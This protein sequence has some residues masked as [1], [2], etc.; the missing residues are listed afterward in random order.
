M[1]ND[2]RGLSDSHRTLRSVVS[3]PPAAARPGIALGRPPVSSVEDDFGLF[4]L[5]LGKPRRRTADRL[6]AFVSGH[7][8]SD[9]SCRGLLDPVTVR[10]PREA[11]RTMAATAR[12]LQKRVGEI[13]PGAPT[14]RAALDG[15]TA[16]AILLIVRFGAA[17]DLVQMRAVLGEAL[18]RMG[19]DAPRIWLKTRKPYLGLLARRGVFDRVMHRWPRAGTFSRVLPLDSL[20]EADHTG[21]R[22]YQVH[23]AELWA[24]YFLR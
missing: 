20:V 9:P 13:F 10:G 17:G 23:R 19:P 7:S 24:R 16:K 5:D 12:E 11:I 22:R 4:P 18:R 14:F 2:R 3:P 1:R 21:R 15:L 6:V 8:L